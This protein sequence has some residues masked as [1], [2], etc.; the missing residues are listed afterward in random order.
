MQTLSCL[1]L[2]VS[3]LQFAS[4]EIQAIA[5]RR[6]RECCMARHMQACLVLRQ[7]EYILNV[8]DYVNENYLR[9]KAK[10]LRAI[11][12]VEDINV[13]ESTPTSPSPRHKRDSGM[14]FDTRMTLEETKYLARL[15]TE[16]AAWD[17]MQM[18]QTERKDLYHSLL[19]W[20]LPLA[21]L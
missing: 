19:P 21:L 20:G 14:P 8:T 3:A 16:L 10:F 1:L 5:H 18:S 6:E 12:Y 11:D 4:I 17:P 15:L 9:V 2:T 7:F 13:G